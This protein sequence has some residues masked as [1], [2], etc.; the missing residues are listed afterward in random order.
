MTRIQARQLAR[1]IKAA[2]LH[3]RAAQGIACQAGAGLL[4]EA[5]E[6]V[7]AQI[8]LGASQA[9]EAADAWAIRNAAA[10]GCGKETWGVQRWCSEPDGALLQG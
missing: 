6:N 1:H 2:L 3:L 4:A 8:L 10:D 5:W 9:V 7:P